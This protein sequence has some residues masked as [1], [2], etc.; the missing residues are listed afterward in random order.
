MD[1]SIIIPTKNGGA[2]FKQV[3]EK[4][5]AQ[6]TKYEYEVICV[7]SGSTDD[8]LDSIRSF[9]CRLYE[10]LPEEFGHGK[11]RNYGASKGTGEFI[12]FVTQDAL[13]Y[14]ELWLEKLIDAMKMDDEIVAGFGRHVPYPDCNIL[15]ARDITLHFKGFGEENTIYYM[16]S[17]ER[18]AAEEGYRHFLAFFS[19][20]NSC[21]R[22]SI[23]EKYPYPDV[24]FSE[25]QIWAK[26]MIELGYKK[27]YCPNAAVYHSHNYPLKTYFKRYYD[28]H[29]GVYRI[30]QYRMYTS[31]RAMI[32]GMIRLIGR[33]VLYIW[34]P[35]NHIRGKI[36]WTYYASV[37]NVYRSIAGFI[38]GSYHDLSPT[39]KQYFD[40]RISQQYEQIFDKNGDKKEVANKKDFWKWLFINP[41]RMD[42][43]GRIIWG[44]N[45]SVFGGIDIQQA[46]GYVMN[47]EKI[48]FDQNAYLEARD[49]KKIINWI[50]PEMGLCS[51]GH[52]NIFRFATML[53]NAG[54]QN[55][56][57]ILKPYNFFTDEDCRAFLRKNYALDVERIEVYVNIAKMGFA[58][59]TIATAWNTAYYLNKFD[60]TISK[61][62][63]VQ[64]FEPLFY[65]VGSDYTFAENTYKMGFRGLTAGDWLKDKLHDEYGMKTSS[66]LFSY[67]HD[68]YVEGKKRDDVPRI[69]FYARPVTPRRDFELGLL[70]LHEITKRKP[71]VEVVFAGWDVSN[72]NIPFRHQ[73]L[74]SVSLDKLSDLYAQCDMCLVISGTNLSLLPLEVMASNSVPV[75]SKGDNSEWL[76]N[77]DVAVM[78]DIEP[79]AIADTVCYYFEHPQELQE[80][81]KKGLEF[82]HSTDWE[83]E[84]KKVYEAIKMGIEEDEKNINIRR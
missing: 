59:A 32:Y 71:E 63:F 74:G 11:T 34:K 28:E 23:W 37:R 51:G 42:K 4:I 67:D 52:I 40:Q 39:M 29:K 65:P 76:V 31:I 10:I 45:A 35:G 24:D 78:V 57:Y 68:L 55:K 79:N 83:L 16:E 56:I 43:N 58:H 66:F 6:K 41:D 8:T 47:R 60:N 44:S 69:F 70:A 77:D 21:L 73:N 50:I 25:D 80:V 7:D 14:D 26:Q 48:P 38:A 5:F 12:V 61:F 33:D 62:Y 2:L 22:R 18:Y 64:D 84:G 53:Q 9:P 1:V 36:K 72:Y 19:D 75:C 20:N 82:A 27:V 3:L 54:F 17:Q 81:R 30:H 46:Y 15:D 49:G 13:P